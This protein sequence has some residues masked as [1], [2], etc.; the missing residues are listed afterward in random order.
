MQDAKNLN[1]P[2]EARIQRRVRKLNQLDQSGLN[3]LRTNPLIPLCE[4]L[5]TVPPAKA[6]PYLSRRANVRRLILDHDPQQMLTQ[7]RVALVKAQMWK[8]ELRQY[9]M[10]LRELLELMGTPSVHCMQQ[11][12]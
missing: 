4:I 1:Q 2:L 5:T 8:L 7:S 10:N 6:R 3:G 11:V 9:V 12:T